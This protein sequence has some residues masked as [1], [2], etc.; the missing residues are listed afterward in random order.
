MS[1]LIGEEEVGSQASVYLK[2]V[3]S[4]RLRDALDSGGLHADINLSNRSRRI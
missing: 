3:K 2:E 4:R 1:Y